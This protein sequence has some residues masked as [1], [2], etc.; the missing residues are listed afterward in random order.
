MYVVNYKCE[1]AKLGPGKANLTP[2]PTVPVHFPTNEPRAHSLTKI[3]HQKSEAV[4]PRT[5]YMKAQDSV[6]LVHG[7]HWRAD[8]YRTV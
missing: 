5:Q 7:H 6:S 3:S 1:K 8:S 2:S 4:T